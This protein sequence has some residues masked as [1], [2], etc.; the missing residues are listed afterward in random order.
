[1]QRSLPDPSSDRSAANASPTAGRLGDFPAAWVEAALERL[2][3]SDTFRRSQ[4]HRRFLAHVVGAGLAG[5]HDR[6]KEIII[7]LEVFGRVLPGYD[8][9]ED[10][11]VRVEAGRIR[12]KLERFYDGEGAAES[13]RIAI[14]VGGYLPRFTR[15]APVTSSPVHS[16]LAVMPFTNLGSATAD[17]A[18]LLG[19]ADQLIDTLGRVSGL[20]VVARTSATKVRDGAPDLRAIGKVL[21]VDH[22][23]E[24]SLQRSGPRMRCFVQLSRVKDGM[25]RW[26][27][28]FEH[29]EAAGGDLFDYQDR[30]ADA[31]LAAVTM[32]QGSTTDPRPARSPTASKATGTANREARELFERARHLNQQ[33][34]YDGHDKAA[35]ML[36]RAIALDPS[37]AQGHSHLGNTLLNLAGMRI[38][39][40]ASSFARARTVARRSVDLDPLDGEAHALMG[41]IACRVDRR[42]LDAEPMFQEALRLSPNSTLVHVSYAWCLAFNGRFD[43]AIRHVELARQLDPLNLGLRAD[44]AAIANVARRFDLAIDEF[45]AVLQFEPTPQ[46]SHLLL[47]VTCL[48]VGEAERALRLFERACEMEPWHPHPR[49]LRVNA[50]ARLGDLD[51]GWRE[52]ATLMQGLGDGDCSRFNVAGTLACLG[53]GDGVFANL[54]HA[55]R[56]RDVR[57]VGLPS[58]LFFEPYRNDPRYEDLLRRTGLTALPAWPG[59]RPNGPLSG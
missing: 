24:G 27:Q 30:I 56:I 4:R 26:S 36:E 57:F 23:V 6:L 22:L 3:D 41:T 15:R 39:P 11:I 42:W 46:F 7:G 49:L 34:T 37:F 59:R 17:A 48:N 44:G 35:L 32:L 52:F 51:R 5:R 50:W 12:D 54:E 40:D 18:F 53:D 58:H 31:V 1:M 2:L 25:R 21:G 14:P 16:A 8:P 10:P 9:R 33:K 43:Q 47:G 38:A 13:Y 20:K 55:A 28:R 29:D 19:L 45:E